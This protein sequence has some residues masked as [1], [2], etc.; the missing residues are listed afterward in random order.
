LRSKLFWL[1]DWI[2]RYTLFHECDTLGS[3]LRE[4]GSLDYNKGLVCLQVQTNFDTTINRQQC[5]IWSLI[6]GFRLEPYLFSLYQ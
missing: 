6:R 2:L 4:E 5:R 3:H 1:L